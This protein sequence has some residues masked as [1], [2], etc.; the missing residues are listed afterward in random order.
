MGCM[1]L[2]VQAH[3]M[4]CVAHPGFR[5]HEPMWDEQAVELLFAAFGCRTWPVRSR[6]CRFGCAS[7]RPAMRDRLATSARA[8]RPRRTTSDRSAPPSHTAARTSPVRGQVHF[9]MTRTEEATEGVVCIT[10]VRV[11][12]ITAHMLLRCNHDICADAVVC[13][14]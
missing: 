5:L 1:A 3:T 6:C 8:S 11:Q 14:A 4:Y 10:G 2:A 7:N 13:K 12:G 9:I